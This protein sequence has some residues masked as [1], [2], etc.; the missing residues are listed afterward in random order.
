MSLGGFGAKIH[1]SR[2]HSISYKICVVIVIPLTC[3]RLRAVE[4]L[5]ASRMIT[6][7]GF[8]EPNILQDREIIPH[9]LKVEFL[10]GWKGLFHEPR[11]NRRS[12]RP[13]PH[14][15]TCDQQREAIDGDAA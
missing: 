7:S 11:P 1:L 15:G 2:R 5:Q 3:V 8:R 12:I 10:H 4:G 14:D 6:S 13:F 9:V